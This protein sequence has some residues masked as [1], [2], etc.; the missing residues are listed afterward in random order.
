[1]CVLCDFYWQ[2]FIQSKASFHRPVVSK[3]FSADDFMK[4]YKYEQKDRRLF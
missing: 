4:F 1:M 3:S 2:A